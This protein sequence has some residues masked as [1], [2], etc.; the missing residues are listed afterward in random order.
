MTAAEKW[1]R[2]GEGQLFS[3]RTQVL[4]LLTLKS[5]YRFQPIPEIECLLCR[6]AKQ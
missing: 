4:G 2:F 5:D 1:A 6:N 3:E